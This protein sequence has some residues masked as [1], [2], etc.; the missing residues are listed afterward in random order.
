MEFISYAQLAKDLESFCKIL[1]R[2]DLVVGIPKSGMLVA[3]MMAKYWN[4]E[5][6]RIESDD[7]YITGYNCKLIYVV[8]DSMLAGQTMKYVMENIGEDKRVKYLVMYD[9]DKTHM[10]GMAPYESFRKIIGCRVFQWNLWNH[11]ELLALSCMDMDGVLCRPP[12]ERENDDGP[13]YKK[14]L[15]ETEPWFIPQHPVGAIVTAR[16]SKYN[17]Q[18]IDWLNKHSIK[19][20]N[21]VMLNMESK[22]ERLSYINIHSD[23][24]STIYHKLSNY[25]IFIEDEPHQAYRINML[26]GRPVICVSNWVLYN[27]VIK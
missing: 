19:Y 21:L 11:K 9:S 4:T 7:F 18:T 3:T 2:P 16:L 8:D 17:Q 20:N 1:K 22:A 24:K 23:F 5:V 12:T 6:C 26:I 14:F 25:S 27:K 10:E 13:L 15:V